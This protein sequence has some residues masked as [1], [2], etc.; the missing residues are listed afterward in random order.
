MC[1]ARNMESR[2]PEVY[3]AVTITLVAATAALVLRIIARRMKKL[4]L[5]FDDYLAMVAWVSEV[6]RCEVVLVQE[7]CAP[8]NYPSYPV[9]KRRGTAPHRLLL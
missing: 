2:Q 6:K 7:P 8:S 5:W 9:A 1:S 3:G 4:A